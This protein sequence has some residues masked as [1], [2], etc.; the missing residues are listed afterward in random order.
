MNEGFPCAIKQEKC[1]HEAFPSLKRRG[2][3]ALRKRRDATEMAQPGWSARRNVSECVFNPFAE[4]T[5][6]AASLRNGNFLL[7]WRPPLLFKEGKS[8]PF[9]IVKNGQSPVG[10]HRPP[11]QFE[12]FFLTP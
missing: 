8:H 10:G 11:L 4:L 5:T 9:L 6:P 7:I 3:C 1:G 12:M 2:G